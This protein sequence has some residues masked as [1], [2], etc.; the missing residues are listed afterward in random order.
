MLAMKIFIK[1][2]LIALTAG[3]LVASCASS[4]TA[5][6]STDA[7]TDDRI[8]IKME[9]PEKKN[10]NNVEVGDNNSMQLVDYLRRVPGLIVDQRGSSV[11]V[12]IR[13]INSI[14]G[15]NNPLFVVNSSP[16]GNSYAE[17]V[18]AVDINDIKS[19]NVIK[20]PEGQQMYGMRGANGVVQILTKRK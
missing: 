3:F 10:P 6:S 2:T 13:G 5:N 9:E 14:T 20:G 17:A 12:L 7:T 8:S 1:Q 19:V 18:N 16:V 4:K 11:T 15:D